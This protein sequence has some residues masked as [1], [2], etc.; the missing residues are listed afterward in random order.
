VHQARFRQT[1]VE[2]DGSTGAEA[3]DV[4]LLHTELPQQR[5]GVGRHLLDAQRPVD[6]G[7]VPVCLLLDGDHPP[8][9]GQRR[10]EI[11]E[12][13]ADARQ[14]AVQEHEG[15]GGLR[16]VDLVVHLEI[17]DRG[18][19]AGGR[20]TGGRR[21]L[22]AVARTRSTACDGGE[23]GHRGERDPRCPGHG[24]TPVECGIRTPDLGSS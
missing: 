13:R 12:V 19:P 5:R 18:V 8:V 22:R 2:R 4:G 7:G 9:P 21:R 10:D 17:A 1:H 14:R 6:I 15:P 3:E 16:A 24:G 20:G 11:A 23:R